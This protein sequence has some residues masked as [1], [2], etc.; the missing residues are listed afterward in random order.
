VKAAVC[1]AFGAPLAIEEVALASPQSGEVRVQVKA[2]GICQSD[3]HSI[4]GAWG[5]TLP[6]IFGHEAA[7]VIDAL[8][9]GVDHL[10]PGDHVMV[11]LIRSCGRCDFCVQGEP[12]FCEASFRLDRESP[13]TDRDG[14]PIVQG[15]HT[16][17]FAESILV[18]ASQAV[19]IP[20]DVPF[21]AACLLACAVI[22]GFGAVVNTAGV[23]A[24]SSVVVVGTGGVGL[25]AVQA[26]VL[27][28]ARPVIAVDVSNHK[29]TAARTFGA[30][31]TV[32]PGEEQLDSAVAAITGGRRA[33]TVIVTAGSTTA[34]EQGI[35]LA[36]RGGTVVL[37]GMPPSGVATIDPGQIAHDGQRILGSKV[38]ASRPRIDLPRLISLYRDG[39]LKLDQLVSHKS[40]LSE[41][42]AAI[43]SAGR[44]DV[45]RNVIVF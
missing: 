4:E 25:N 3:V 21:E 36:R 6:A 18:D 14:N 33:D 2:C 12:V 31:H 45:V 24:G 20:D 37:V 34:V 28:G 23:Q 43:A 11:S 29:L 19:P 35:T 39:R 17:A 32:N 42:N 44:G 38:G 10:R 22:T 8:G 26:A 15:M 5:G 30:T 7:G 9:A 27:S 40:P 1:R 16:G 13:I 41:I